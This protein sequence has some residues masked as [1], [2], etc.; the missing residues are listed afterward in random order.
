MQ[1]KEICQTLLK[2]LV[3]SQRAFWSFLLKRFHENKSLFP[4][5]QLSTITTCLWFCFFFGKFTVNK[6]CEALTTQTP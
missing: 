4:F 5:L 2:Y 6:S 1:F 3:S